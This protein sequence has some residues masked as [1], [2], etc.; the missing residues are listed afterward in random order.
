MPTFGPATSPSAVGR[1]FLGAA[2][3]LTALLG[4]TGDARW[5]AASGAFGTVWWAWD[6][7]SDSVFGPLGSWLLGILTGSATVEEPPDLTL[8]DTIRLLE[9][10]LTADG[11][12]R[13]VQIQAALR[14]SAQS[15]GPS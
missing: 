8:D 4:L 12:T 10:H 6:F 7:L 13:H 15:E 5:F 9:D 2:T 11:V 3:V 14:L 1:T